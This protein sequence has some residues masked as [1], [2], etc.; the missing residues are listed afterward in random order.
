MTTSSHAGPHRTATPTPNELHTLG[1]SYLLARM[2]HDLATVAVLRRSCTAAELLNGVVIAAATFAH[3]AAPLL[4]M[5]PLDL[6]RSNVDGALG[7]QADEVREAMYGPARIA[8]E[9]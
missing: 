3:V 7:N 9:S 1:A 6:A 5:R 4:G 8:G 2:S